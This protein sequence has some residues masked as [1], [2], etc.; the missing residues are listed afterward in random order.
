MKKDFEIGPYSKIDIKNDFDRIYVLYYARLRRFAKSYVL[1]DADAE[2]VVQDV[3]VSLWTRSGV[4]ILRS[5]LDNYMF[6][7]VKN[8]CIDFLRHKVVVES[9]R[10]DLAMKLESLEYIDEHISNDIDI[11]KVVKEAVRKLPE[12]CREVFLKSRSEGKKYKEIAEDLGISENTV[13]TQ[14]SIAFRRLREELRKYLPVIAF[15]MILKK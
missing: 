7:L 3:F 11:E 9:S 12:R 4:I 10:M 1:S 13:E 8:R 2:N 15:F 14:M 6:S 5:G